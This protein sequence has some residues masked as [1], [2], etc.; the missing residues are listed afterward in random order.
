MNGRQERGMLIAE[1]NRIEEGMKG[2]IVPSQSG[3]GI[4][5]VKTRG[6]GTCTCPDH[7]MRG[8]R[9]KH[10]YAVEYFIQ[11]KTNKDGSTTVTKTKRLTYPQNWR[12]YNKAQTSELDLFDQ[13]LK[14]LVENVDEP[15]Q[16]RGRTTVK[17]EREY[18]LRDTESL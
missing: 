8:I 13:L 12:A 17:P 6:D 2:Y 15:P 5:L 1:K 9:C 4:Y 11:E 7:Q 16:D 10:Q 3:N 14:D 18:L